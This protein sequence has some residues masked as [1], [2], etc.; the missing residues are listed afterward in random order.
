[1]DYFYRTTENNITALAP[2]HVF[3]FGSNLSG[4]HGGGAAALAH[5]KFGAIWGCA[6]GMQGNC[7]AIPTKNE[8]IERTLTINEIKPYVNE[9][10]LWAKARSYK[11]YLV[12]EI[13]C[14]LA[15]YQPQDIAPLFKEAMNVQN[16]HLP[17]KFWEILLK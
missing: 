17:E 16:I 7:Y 4:I 15:G 5:D 1:M 12:T 13:G 2:D 6:E 10:I 8:G 11:T 9:F 14:G 3:V